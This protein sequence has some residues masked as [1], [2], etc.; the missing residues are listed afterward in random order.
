MK[1][2]VVSF[3]PSINTVFFLEKSCCVSKWNRA[4][5]LPACRNWRVL[6]WSR[7]H[8]HCN[9]VRIAERSFTIIQ[10]CEHDKHDRQ[11]RVKHVMVRSGILYSSEG[12][13]RSHSPDRNTIGIMSLLALGRSLARQFPSKVVR[14][15]IMR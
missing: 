14:D 9:R 13:V 1:M 12:T 15:D 7:Q 4:F 2:V 3:V 10:S 11:L 5:V 8:R 6:A